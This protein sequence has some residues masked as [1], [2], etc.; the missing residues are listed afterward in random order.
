M[1]LEVRGVSIGYAGKV[2]VHDVSLGLKPGAL[3]C[4]LGPSGCGKT[5]LLRAIAGFEPVMAGE[6]VLHGRSV[7]RPGSTL[8]PERRR[9]GMVFQDLALFPHLTV[10]DNIA[11]GLRGER[12]AA[13]RARVEELLTLV[14]LAG[15]GGQYP[16][17]LSGGQ[18]QRVALARAMAP[19]PDL[20]LLDEPFS[21]MDVELREKLARE[22]RE[23]LKQDGLTALLVTHDQFEAF[24]I[25][26]EIGV[27]HQGRLVQWDSAYNLYHEPAD[28]FVAD[29]IG[30]GVMLRG[31][32]LNDRQVEIELGIVDGVVPRGCEKGCPVDVLVRPDDIQH[33]DDSP[34]MAEVSA[35]AFRGAEFLYTLTLASGARVL[36]FAPS[37]HNH[38]I[39]ER[40]GIRVMIDHVVMFPVQQPRRERAAAHRAPPTP[41]PRADADA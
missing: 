10:S 26:D 8:P 30:Q 34:L 7:S 15:Y 1:L 20:L 6:I 23:I 19:R 14:G 37:H 21:S 27:M 41:V 40:I 32:V 33:D 31:T 12:A 13:R 9:V 22:V 4:L 17:Q 18:Q 5:T 28:R 16:H 38:A 35:K 25:A 11:F 3:G 36:C 29:F 24:A 39:G 2:V